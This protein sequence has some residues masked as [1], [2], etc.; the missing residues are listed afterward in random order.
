MSAK[1]V[2]LA[3]CAGLFGVM[4]CAHQQSNGTRAYGYSEPEMTPS[5]PS[6]VNNGGEVPP[7]GSARPGERADATRMGGPE[8]N[9]TM[10]TSAIDAPA[11]NRGNTGTQQ[12]ATG[13]NAATAQ[14]A[15]SEDCQLAVYF[16]TDSSALDQTSQQRLDRVAECMKRHQVDHATIVGQTDPSGTA[17][18]NQQLGLER[19]RAVAEYLRSRGVPDRDI[20]VRSKGEV[21]AAPAQEL[22]PVDRRAG[23][24]VQ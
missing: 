14:A 9:N 6:A 22:W 13:T 19:A 20:R 4:G 8:K 11:D 15:S 5:E 1:Q 10:T 2:K 17:Q 12:G 16:S 21:A 18:H 7:I 24:Q 23:V 3:L